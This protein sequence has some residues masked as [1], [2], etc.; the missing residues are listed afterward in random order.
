MNV[1]PDR[2]AQARALMDLIAWQAELGADV[3]MAEQPVDR[4]ALPVASPSTV[5]ARPVRGAPPPASSAPAPAKVAERDPAL[6]AG[7]SAAAAT[8]LEELQ[9]AIAA[10][11]GCALKRGATNCVFSDGLAGA[12][13]MIVGE[14]PGRDEDR[15]GKPFVGRA[16]Q[17]L[18]RMLAA[19]GLSRQAP[20]RDSAV[21]ISNILPWRPPQNR[22]PTPEEIAMMRPFIERHIALA[23]PDFL[24][25]MGN[26]A[27]QGLFDEKGITRLRG[28]WV[29][30][31][32]R[33]C[34]PM[35]HPAYLLRN[36]AAKRQAWADLLA[37]RGC[38]DLT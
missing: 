27:C 21:Y 23:E 38:L 20:D 5:P 36:P 7:Q 22:T 32:G 17:L 4:F 15:Q 8:T 6:E 1:S 19:V 3:P 2:L 31:G 34:L 16:G 25:A 14:A 26:V 11:D 24:V 33:P 10:F 18:D 9:A 37:L 13:V 29:D 35:F 12:R 30:V 28:R